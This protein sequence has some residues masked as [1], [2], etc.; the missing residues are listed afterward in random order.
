VIVEKE[1]YEAETIVR[2]THLEGGTGPMRFFLTLEVTL[3]KA[4]SINARVGFGLRT[5]KQKTMGMVY[6]Q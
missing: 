2:T 4:D 3:A 1:P 6:Y 5:S